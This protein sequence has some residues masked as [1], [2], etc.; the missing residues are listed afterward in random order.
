M[1]RSFI[2]FILLLHAPPAATVQTMLQPQAA[3]IQPVQAAMQQATSQPSQV[4]TS[5][6]VAAQPAAATS[7]SPSNISVAALQTAGLSINPAI[8]RRLY[9]LLFFLNAISPPLSTRCR[10]PPSSTPLPWELSPSFSV[11]S[12]P[13]P[14]SPVRCPTWLA[15]PVRSSQ[16]PKDRQVP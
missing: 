12:P 10:L 14:S 1:L 2:Y 13:P 6:A 15:S 16:T 11:P 5:A 7:V 4:T 3:S 8:V 9:F